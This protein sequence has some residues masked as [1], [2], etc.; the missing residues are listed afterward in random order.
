MEFVEALAEDSDVW[1]ILGIREVSFR[2]DDPKSVTLEFFCFSQKSKHS[3]KRKV[4]N[5]HLPFI[6]LM[7]IHPGSLWQHGRQISKNIRYKKSATIYPC[8]SQL[9]VCRDPLTTEDIN[10]LVSR[11]KYPH[12][13]FISVT[14]HLQCKD[15][16]D[17]TV[18]ISCAEIIR[19]FLC[20][21]RRFAKA[22]INGEFDIFTNPDHPD[23]SAASLKSNEIKVTKF[24]QSTP[25]GLRAA[26]YP[27]KMLKI[28]RIYNT[29]NR[30]H[31]P[32]LLCALLPTWKEI[33]IRMSVYCDDGS[34][35]NVVQLHRTTRIMEIPMKIFRPVNVNTRI[36]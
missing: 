21:T 14:S 27:Y 9:V 36:I 16:H 23:R 5:F 11:S 31:S 1:E 29:I 17:R 34:G 15:P 30:Q 35:T 4:K 6:A 32:V 24:L 26:R 12:S 3:Y 7:H 18:R 19:H 20:P 13:T 22:I 25:E 8:H 2:G 33:N 28:T 10:A